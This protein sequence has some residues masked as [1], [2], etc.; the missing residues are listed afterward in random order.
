M[1]NLKI[2]LTILL[3][4]L[5]FLASS[6]ASAQS[7]PQNISSINVDDLSDQQIMQL[8]QQAQKA[9]LTDDEVIQQAQLRG[10]PDNQVQ[11]LKSRIQD[12]RGKNPVLKKSSVDTTNNANNFRGRRQNFKTDSLDTLSKKQYLFDN[13]KPKIFGADLFRNSNSN[14]F[15]PN[16]NLAT[17]IN[18]IVGPNDQININVYGN[19]SVDWSLDVSP[20]GNINIPSV[21]IVNVAGKTIEMVTSIIRNKLKANNYTIGKGTDVK[22]SLGNIR[23]IQVI[24]QGQVVKP[25]T[26]TLPSWQ[27]YLM[28]C[29]QQAGQMMLAHFGR[30]K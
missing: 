29:L 21:G 28:H 2:F 10:L 8:L 26:Y 27:R 23:S 13:L 20:E 1:N 22:V 12:V 18:Y 25:G 14:T 7:L 17:P 6:P 5:C 19:S 9:G 24:V 4:F 16:L 15:Q 3:V 30:S 11:K